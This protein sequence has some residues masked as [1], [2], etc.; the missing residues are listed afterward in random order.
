MAN[1]PLDR[2]SFTE[3]RF[4]TKV[5]RCPLDTLVIIHVTR[6]DRSVDMYGAGV[7]AENIAQRQQMTATVLIP[8]R[9]SIKTMCLGGANIETISHVRRRLQDMGV[10]ENLRLDCVPGLL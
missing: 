5:M 10:S 7:A 4:H 3:N 8:L 1:V 6:S 9:T 2:R